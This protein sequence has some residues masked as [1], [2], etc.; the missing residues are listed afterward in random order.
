MSTLLT[1]ILLLLPQ[2]RP[3]VVKPAPKAPEQR[4]LDARK[5]YGEGMLNAKRGLFLDAVKAFEAV[6]KL[7]PDSL[8]ARRMLAT[9]YLRI[10]R[11]DDALA[12]AK[13]VTEKA[14]DDFTSWQV[15]AS[16]LHELRRT[17]EAVAALAKAS[18]LESTAKAPDVL[19]PMLSKL[20]NWSRD[21][22]DHAGAANALRR[23]LA[24]LDKNRERFRNSEFLDDEAWL[25]EKFGAHERLGEALLRLDRLDA[26]VAEFEA[27]RAVFKG[28]DDTKAQVRRHRLTYHVAQVQFASKEYAAAYQS[29]HAFMTV[30]RPGGLE[31]Y[32]LLAEI[33]LQ[34]DREKAVTRF[35]EFAGREKENDNIPLQLLRAEVLARSGSEHAAID[36]YMKLAK[37][38][39]RT[40]VYRALFD[41]YER[42]RHVSEALAQ[43]DEHCDLID[44]PDA[45]EEAKKKAEEHLRAINAA[46]LKQPSMI[47]KLLPAAN[48]EKFRRA[49]NQN[50]GYNTF[51]RLAWLV[52][53]TDRLED[54]ERL[55]RDAL[56][57]RAASFFPV[58]YDM[59]LLRVLERRHKYAEVRDLCVERKQN[60][61]RIQFGNLNEFYYNT[62]LE[63]ALLR[64]GDVA[65]ALRVNEQ[66]LIQAANESDKVNTRLSRVDM[67]YQADKITEAL[68]EC[69]KVLTDYPQPKYARSIRIK[70][71]TLLKYARRPAAGEK[72]LR[73]MLDA[74]P[75]DV[76][77]LNSLGYEL[78]EQS[79]N[80]DE[81]ER[82]IRRAL[83]L[84]QRA[85]KFGD[86]DDESPTADDE[87]RAAYLDSLAWVLFRKG[88]FTEARALLEKAVAQLDGRD[89]AAL[90]DHLGDVYYRMNEL[91]K[92]RAAWGKAKEFYAYEPIAKKDGR[93]DELSRKLNV[94]K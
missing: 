9:H 31:P 45:G 2:D 66:S 33:V 62:H 78:A 55:F 5:L 23:Y 50:F 14:P 37:K 40:D 43:I 54:A 1:I 83:E 19:A 61:D 75:N 73:E 18:E 58:P 70:M 79:R 22:G 26:A 90:W 21:A 92:A 93:L 47:L 12:M 85:R 13:E 32:R 36:L 25:D 48:E 89:D 76:S 57:G 20:A 63:T 84:D 16:Q 56:T 72:L 59:A 80:L 91:G 88:K 34:L 77:V 74:D 29:L 60:L 10:A 35:A 38:E 82:L 30:V 8:P 42:L 44:K 68:A 49:R 53:Q 39:P 69:E 65:E 15:Y 17:K 11:P 94:L 41:L 64:L 67:L 6:L 51:G 81:A 3:E 28:R 87:D 27:A 52:A 4:E 7:D 86:G 46:L 71:A 24:V